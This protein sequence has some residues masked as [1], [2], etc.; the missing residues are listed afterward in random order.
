MKVPIY[1]RKSKYT[2]KGDPIGNQIQMYKDH[3]EHL[4]KNKQIEYSI[5]DDEGFS[6]KNTEIPEFQK[7]SND[8]T[9]EKFSILVCYGLDRISSN[10]V[11]FSSTLDEL[12][13]YGIDFVSI[14]EQF[15]TTSPMGRAMIYIT[16]VFAQ[17]EHETIVK[18]VIVI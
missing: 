18:R 3:I 13:A 14:G 12:Q 7:L 16:S 1:S 9:K 11:H 5:Y 6:G 2:S 8:I 15:D 4:Y 17:L 10:V